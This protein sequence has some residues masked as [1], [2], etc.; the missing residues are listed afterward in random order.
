MLTPSS[1]EAFRLRVY[2][3]MLLLDTDTTSSI[4]DL[5]HFWD[6]CSAMARQCLAALERLSSSPRP[7]GRDALSS[8]ECIAF[9]AQLLLTALLALQVGIRDYALIDQVITKSLALLPQLKDIRLCTHLLVHLYA[10]TEDEALYT[11]L[12]NALIEFHSETEE[13]QYLL[14]SIHTFHGVE[15]EI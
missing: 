11:Q 9:R 7:V 4:Q 14:Q 6:E 2:R 12:Q 3:N 8:A 13:D 1:L 5:T 10:E 15:S